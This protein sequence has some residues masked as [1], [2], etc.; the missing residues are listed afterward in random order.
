VQVALRVFS[1]FS[2]VLLFTQK[3]RKLSVANATRKDAVKRRISMP[4]MVFNHHLNNEECQ[5]GCEGY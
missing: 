2:V 4:W 1:N 3:E 5:F